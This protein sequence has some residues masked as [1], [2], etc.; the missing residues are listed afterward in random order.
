[1]EPTK[2]EVAVCKFMSEYSAERIEKIE[3]LTWD[4][5][6]EV[7]GKEPV[8]PP[9]DLNR[10]ANYLGL[11]IW[12]GSFQ[13]ERIVGA[14]DKT[15]RTIYLAEDIPYVRKA[16]TM[17][18]EIGHFLLHEQRP[19]ETFYRCDMD[20]VEEENKL[21]EQEANWFSA[22]LLMPRRVVRSLWLATKDSTEVARMCGVSSLAA[23]YRLANLGLLS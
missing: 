14:Y 23:H 19:K 21:E 16:F 3:C 2:S 5:L 6:S 4:L 22:S 13:D 15:E 7:Y 1:M 8:V 17:G 9:I 11:E 12:Q 20:A 10:V 18:H